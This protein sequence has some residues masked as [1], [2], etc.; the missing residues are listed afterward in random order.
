[1]RP[2]TDRV[3]L[4]KYHE[5]LIVCSACL[6]GE[7]PRKILQGKIEE[8]EAAIQ[9]YKN[10]FGSDFYLELQRHKATVARAN[11]EAYELQQVANAKIIELAKKYDVKLVCTNDVH[12][13][14]EEN[15]EAHD[16]LICL[17][18][19]KDL[20]DPN[21]MLYSKQ[22]WMK[23]KA[24]MNELFADVPEALA[25]TAAI[26]D[27]VEFYSIDHAPI[28]PNFEIPE[29]FGTEEGYRL[30]YSEKDLFDEFTQD[31]N[32]N[33][34]LSE[35][36]A[37]GKIEKLGGYDKLYRIKLEADYLKKLALEGAH[38]RYGEIL[39]EETSERIKFELHI[40]KP[41]GFPGYF[42][43][44]QD[45]I[46]AAR[47]ELDVSVGPGRGS[48][49]GSAVAYCLGITQIDPIKYD[50]LFER[51]L[52]PDRISLPDIDVDFDDDGRG[53]VLNWVTE[54]Y[55]QEK[56]AH[57]ITYGTM[58]TKL[59]IKDVARVQKL[60]LSESDRLCKAIPDRLPS[61]KKMNL[62]NAIEDVPELQ[63]AEVHLIR[64]C[65]IPSDM[66]RC[67]REMSA[68][69][70]CMLVVRLS[71]ETILPTGFLSVQPMIRKPVKKCW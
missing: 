65:V 60:P 67:W 13:V 4:E 3:E 41:M 19:G 44:V 56:V 58:A 52:N 62:P 42:L 32:G 10:I 50:L 6:A 17:S 37:H 33:V 20:D 29:E 16:R 21:R 12:F 24:E 5:G 66:L 54:K 8:A 9:W 47:E 23:T 59:A 64:Y 28:M 55:G 46:R 48:A 40:M 2:R 49:A 68:I 70:G 7:V 35:D 14:D 30:K 39:D 51:F 57:I 71:V 45:F 25:N 22:E 63:E 34:V 31:E 69:R 15:A 38:R 27:Q 1:M 43:I 36:A 61:G 26:C 53:R 18:T 11:H